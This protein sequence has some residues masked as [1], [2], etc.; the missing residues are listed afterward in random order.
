MR[1][2]RQ[3]ENKIQKC[4]GLF[5]AF[6]RVDFELVAIN[7]I[8][9]IPTSVINDTTNMQSYWENTLPIQSYIEDLRVIVG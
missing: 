8:N 6:S 2:L 1:L 9:I 5:L 4:S 7:K 3:I